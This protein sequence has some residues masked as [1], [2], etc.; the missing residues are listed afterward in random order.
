MRNVIILTFIGVFLKK[1]AMCEKNKDTQIG[2][3]LLRGEL[4][5]HATTRFI[6]H[7][8]Y[9]LLLYTTKNAS[10]SNL[11]AFIAFF[12]CIDIDTSIHGIS[13]QKAFSI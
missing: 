1:Y 7:I 6:T 2:L 10:S 4:V 5:D 8:V 3:L 13:A 12:R 11:C 9:R